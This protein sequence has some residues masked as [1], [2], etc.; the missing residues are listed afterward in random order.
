[1]ILEVEGRAV[2]EINDYREILQELSGASSVSVSLER[3]GEP[4]NITITM[5]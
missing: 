1:M 5:D 3:G 4:M 2:A